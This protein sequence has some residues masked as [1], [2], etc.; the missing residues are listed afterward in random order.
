MKK[1]KIGAVYFFMGLL[2]CGLVGVCSS[3][4][5]E[6]GNRG[7]KEA[8]TA[9]LSVSCRPFGV[10]SETAARGAGVRR[11]RVAET[12]EVPL[13]DRWFL[14]ATLETEE[15]PVRTA[16]EY[17]EIINGARFMVVAYEQN[18]L[19]L[20]Y[21]YLQHTEYVYVYD[22]VAGTGRLV[23]SGATTIELTAETFYKYV[24]YSYNSTTEVP[25][26]SPSIGVSTN[27][28]ATLNHDLL[29]GESGAVKAG[30]PIS[31]SL[32][33]LFTRVK[34]RVGTIERKV[35]NLNISAATFETNYSG[36]LDVKEGSL[37]STSTSTAQGLAL[38]GV[39]SVS[40]ESSGYVD[41]EY[42]LVYTGGATSVEVKISGRIGSLDF[43]N[44]VLTFGSELKTG[45]SYVLWIRFRKGLG[46]A[47]S[48]VYWEQSLNGGTGSLTFVPHGD[49]CE[50][51]EEMY[52]GVFFRWGGLMGID[53]S[54]AESSG[55]N[56][57][58]FLYIPGYN[59]GTPESST[60]EAKTGQTLTYDP[61]HPPS[62]HTVIIPSEYL[63]QNIDYFAV[64]PT[65]NYSSYRGDICRYLSESADGTKVVKGKYRM[66]TY[67]ELFYGNND[68]NV[69]GA[70]GVNWSSTTPT[71]GYWTKISGS[72]APSTSTSAAGKHVL[73]VGANYSGYAK[74]PAAGWF[75][76]RSGYLLNM[77]YDGWYG[78]GSPYNSVN[79]ANCLH[80]NASAF[81][82]HT[83]ANRNVGR[84]VRCLLDE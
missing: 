16:G 37:S 31:V 79:S 84:S 30:D 15:V 36:V 76:Q 14:S 73:T 3:C 17:N 71:A 64:Y 42:R 22:P 80:F 49:P 63:Y 65:T 83:A 69:A 58:K 38:A 45:E 19:T 59:S 82:S 52:Q 26:Y 43:S 35:V 28:G 8:L 48:N 60:W 51:G 75:E 1:G 81:G 46:W 67:N 29:W 53:P 70:I 33:H 68:G 10:D 44:L 78:S 55:W 13:E 23:K 25:A 6:V 34:V 20:D 27:P 41:S 50:N 54:G 57:S 21:D 74:F 61:A 5:E 39:H 32:E 72:W 2:W 18:A 12:V 66:P 62:L 11:Q 47:A 40:S 24:Y 4:N 56:S 9:E 77:G 7:P